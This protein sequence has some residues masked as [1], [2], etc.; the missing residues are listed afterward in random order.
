V[1][2]D[3]DSTVERRLD[4]LE[5]DYKAL[6]APQN[7]DKRLGELRDKLNAVDAKVEKLKKDNN[8]K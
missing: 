3:Q 2:F 7:L 8:L 5:K 6:N 1:R 4:T